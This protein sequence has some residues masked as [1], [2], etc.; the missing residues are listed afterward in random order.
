MTEER[1]NVTLRQGDS[2]DFDITYKAD[3]VAVDLTGYTAEMVI[4]WP[5]YFPRDAAPV[6]AGELNCDMTITALT[7]RIQA[8]ADAADTGTVPTSGPTYD[9]P[10]VLYQLR[11]R[12]GSEPKKTLISGR[13]Q[14]LPNLFDLVT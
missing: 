5:E 3:G 6:T 12:Q 1:Y 9:G 11:L 10:E 14:V 13:V 2:F 8:H 7:G 4:S